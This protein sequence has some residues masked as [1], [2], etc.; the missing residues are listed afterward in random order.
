MRWDNCHSAILLQAFHL[1]AEGQSRSAD[2]SYH[3]SG[4][5]YGDQG[6][7]QDRF[8]RIRIPFTDDASIENAIHC[9]AVLLVIGLSQESIAERMQYLSPVA[10]RPGAEEWHQQ[11]FG[12]Q[13]QL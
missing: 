3:P 13:R 6:I 11:L 9:W 10:M 8:V 4:R 7:W 5:R 2:R 1:V 12:H